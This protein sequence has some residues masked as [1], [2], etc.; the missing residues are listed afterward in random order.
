MASGNTTPALSHTH[1]SIPTPPLEVVSDEFK[2]GATEEV[3]WDRPEPTPDVF[4]I[5]SMVLLAQQVEWMF[6]RSGNPKPRWVSQS[7]GVREGWT[8][9]DDGTIMSLSSV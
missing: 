2:G 5:K 9:Q 3:D 1:A 7:N 6:N 4:A 8:V